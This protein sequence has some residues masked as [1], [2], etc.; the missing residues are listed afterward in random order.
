MK[1]LR[2]IAFSVTVAGIALTAD[3]WAGVDAHLLRQPDISKTQIT[4]VYAGDIWVVPKEGGTAQRLSSPPG[5]ESFPRFS[6]DGSKIAFTGNYDGNSDVYVVDA[7]GGPVTRVTH[8]PG[9]DRMLDW[10]RDGQSLLFASG[11]ESGS[12]RFMQLY[13]VGWRGGLPEK[14]PIPYAEMA[15][16]SEDGQWV[17]YTPTLRQGTWK[18]YRGGTAPD[19][20]LFN[21]RTLDARRITDDPAT[22]DLP[23]WHGRTVY[24]VSDRGPTGHF[25]L[26]AYSMD[27][28]KVRQVTQFTDMDVLSAGIGPADLVFEAGG[29]LYVLDLETE[30]YRTIDVNI[31]TDLATL[32]PQNKNVGKLAQDPSVSPSGKRVAF[33]AR[34]DL[35]TVPAEH[36]PLINLTRSSGVAERSP[37]WSPDGKQIAYWTDRNGD[38]EL[39]IRPAETRGDEKIIT[40]FGPGFRYALFW[41]PDSRKLAFVDNRMTV[42]IVTPDDKARVKVDELQW[43]MHSSLENYRL[44]WSPDS[45]WLAYAKANANANDSIWLY[46]L[47]NRQKHR[48]TSGFYSEQSPIFDSE[49]KYL[50]LLTD[51]EM[52]PIYGTMDDSTWVYANATRIAAISL[53]ADVPSPLAPRDDLE[54]ESDDKKDSAKP[55]G[56]NDKKTPDGSKDEADKAKK[57]DPT[58]VTIDLE[59]LERRLTVLPP[60]PGNYGMLASVP[61]KVVYLRLPDA[62]ATERKRRLAYYDFKERKEETVLDD[63][64]SFEVTAD[65]K[66]ILV[67]RNRQFALIEPKKDQKFEKPLAVDKLET[68]V[69][70]RAEWRQIFTEAWRLNRDFF[71]DPAMHGLDWPALRERYGRLLDGAVTR[72]DVNFIIGELIGELNASHTYRGGGDSEVSRSRGVGM[73][74]VDW[75][76]DAGAYRV[77]TIVRGAPW[78]QGVRSAL[79]QPGLK[80]KEGDYILAVN[81]I[82]LDVTKDPWSA[83]EGLERQTVAL[84]INQKPSVDGAQEVLVETLSSSEESNLRQLAWVEA[85]RR[86]VDQASDGRIGYVYMP[87]TSTAGQNNLMRQFKAQWDKPGLIIDERFN[88]GG[89]LADRFLELLGRRAYG[90]LAWRY[91]KDQQLPSVAHFG[92][93]AMLIN[94]WAGSGGDAFPWYFHTAQRGPIIGTRTWGGLI[95]PAMGHEL[96]DG[97]T[98]VVPPCRLYG[99]NGQWFAEGHGVDP[100]IEVVEDPAAMARGIDVQLE[101]AIHEIEKQL[102]VGAMPRSV[103]RPDYEK[104]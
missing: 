81:R 32:K 13:R 2:F 63:V 78:D 26:W 34:G 68:M 5:E 85:N 53:R 46:D 8:H 44:A 76:V 69:D 17:A 57:K 58:P 23:M 80:V 91:G 40:T 77:R 67:E 7:S 28:Q 73:L 27:S 82:P 101:R 56:E 43:L 55:A 42:W 61:G 25:N 74:G 19:V 64:N 96:I 31:V 59:G 94:G 71:Y 51:R 98:V 62:G 20:W 47:N 65:G 86:R 9:S 36:G 88:S 90:G 52:N 103:P 49:G 24:F 70:P 99:P 95:G 6:P 15:A 84:T 10:T 16:L 12:Y 87:D 14:L 60:I 75:S 39:A 45:R 83:F 100:D 18:R 22:D 102:M 37:A 33:S 104:R 1:T 54:T 93:Q 72:W 89:R 92:P 79:D 3:V 35:F 29:R 50:Y 21:L 66:K 11:R 4:F 30:R 48:A 41:S 38:Y 97:G